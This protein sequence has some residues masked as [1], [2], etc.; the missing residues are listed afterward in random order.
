MKNKILSMYYWI[1]N[2]KDMEEEQ[3][4]EDKQY[5]N[6]LITIARLQKQLDKKDIEIKT[7]TNLK[8]IYL[9]KIKKLQNRLKQH[10]KK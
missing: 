10:E 7:Q 4:E 3:Q 8:N 9:T 5:N 2:K 6:C 1:K